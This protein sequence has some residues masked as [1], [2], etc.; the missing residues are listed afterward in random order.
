MR[1]DI[2]MNSN[3]IL[4]YEIHGGPSFATVEV[5]LAPGQQIIAEAGAMAYMDGTVEMKTS[6]KGGV[7]KG[8]ARKF[9]GESFFIN[10][11]TGPGKVAFTTG[12]PGDI[13][14]LTTSP[15][16]GGWI[17]SRD[18]FIAGTA[19]VTVSSK[20]G[21]LKSMIGG[22]GAFLTHVKAEEGEGLFFAG[23][24]GAI[25]KHEIPP[26]KE[27]IVDNGLFFATSEHTQFTISKVGGLKSLFFG[28][29]GLVMKF[30]GPAVV[31]TQ[32]RA[33]PQ[34]ISYIVEKLPKS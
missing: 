28:G 34:L 9:T 13:I 15:E 22:E 29:E 21:G 32:S 20:W 18:A 10:T 5:N 27:L 17:L 16:Q 26:G 31:L 1:I 4:D 6:A 33:L 24:Y 3:K 2:P 30:K 11:F 23:G 19:N 25:K 12:L 14:P 7:L 8:I